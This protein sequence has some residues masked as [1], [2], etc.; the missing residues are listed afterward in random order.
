VADVPR[1]PSPEVT[2]TCTASTSS[3]A[4]CLSSEEIVVAASVPL[5]KYS[6][7]VMSQV[8]VNNITPELN[9]MVEETAYHIL[10][11]GDMNTKGQYD[12]YGRRLYEEYPCIGFP[13]TEPWVTNVYLCCMNVNN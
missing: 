2:A 12:E 1:V 6:D 10:K 4:A 7:R 3:S 9:R 13:G 5:P 11:H 8:K